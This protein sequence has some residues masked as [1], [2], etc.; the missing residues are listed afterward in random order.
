MNKVRERAR[1]LKAFR[2]TGDEDY[3]RAAEAL[4]IPL[5]DHIE[6]LKLYPGRRR[7]PSVAKEAR[8]RLYRIHRMIAGGATVHA[9]ARQEVMV[10]GRG[11]HATEDAAI[12]Y[13]CRAYHRD[14]E[15]IEAD[16]GVADRF[17]ADQ[18]S[19][20]RQLDSM[21]NLYR[22]AHQAMPPHCIWSSHQRDALASKTRTLDTF[23]R[24]LAAR[25]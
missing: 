16:V 8:P 18:R 12:H 25:C 11:A 19:L 5:V 22:A 24:M 9:A 14:R 6:Q 7:G 21:A 2:K 1:L 17:I 4:H 10:H 3:K 20:Q 13:L 23:T 15:S